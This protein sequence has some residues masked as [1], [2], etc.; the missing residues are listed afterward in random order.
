MPTAT[1]TLNGWRAKTSTSRC[2]GARWNGSSTTAAVRFPNDA[3]PAAAALRGG[4]FRSAQP[5]GAA[6]DG[7]RLSRHGAPQR[8]GQIQHLIGDLLR[9]D[10]FADGGMGK[11][12]GL[13]LGERG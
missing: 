10:I 7:N 6:A 3:H 5:V 8:A 2:G 9:G 4:V 13:D 1:I 12:L 11:R